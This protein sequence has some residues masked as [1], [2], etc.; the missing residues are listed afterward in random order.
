VGQGFQGPFFPLQCKH[1]FRIKA[2]N[3]TTGNQG[4]ISKTMTVSDKPR[5]EQFAL[6]KG[7]FKIFHLLKEHDHPKGKIEQTTVQ[8]MQTSNISQKDHK[9]SVPT[10]KHQHNQQKRLQGAWKN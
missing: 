3:L 2:Y 7:L 4:T 8:K 10:E 1:K 6:S 5:S 9:A